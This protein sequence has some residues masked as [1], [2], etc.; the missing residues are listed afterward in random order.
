M[1]I[2]VDADAVPRDVKDILVRVSVKRDV[3]VVLV[4]NRWIDKPKAARVT[5]E[6]V[7]L[8]ADAADDYIVAQCGEGDLVITFDIPLAA[9]AVDAGAHV[10]TP[11]GREY[12]ASNVRAQLSRRDFAEQLREEGVMTGGPSA[13]GAS[14]KQAFSNALDRWITRSKR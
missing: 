9:R 2:W 7:G 6:V 13:F 3:D 12:D 11:Y 5:V 10:I 4:A 14:Q 8:S 1:T